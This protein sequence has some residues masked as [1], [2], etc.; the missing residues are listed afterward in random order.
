MVCCQSDPVQLSKSQW[1]HYIWEVCSANRWDALKTA[2]PAAG[3]GQQKGPNYSPR[4]CLTACPTTSASRVEQI[5]LWSLASS[6]IFAW[7][8]PNFLHFFKHLNNFLQGKCFYNQQKAENS[9]QVSIKSQSVDIYATGINKLISYWQT[10]LIIMIPIL[11]NKDVFEHSYN[12]LKF[13]IWNCNY[14]FI[15]LIVCQRDLR[16]AHLLLHRPQRWPQKWLL[17]RSQV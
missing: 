15:S 13:T 1:N 7:P 2:M 3:T 4:Q 10:V 6:A 11:I 14:F 16:I 9:F 8:I 17:Q 5:G 12:D